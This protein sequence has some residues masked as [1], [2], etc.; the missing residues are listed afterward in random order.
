MKLKKIV[1][2]VISTLVMELVMASHPMILLWYLPLLKSTALTSRREPL[3][4]IP[5]TRRLWDGLL[6]GE[7]L[8]VSE[9]HSIIGFWILSTVSNTKYVSI[10]QYIFVVKH[11]VF[12][13]IGIGVLSYITIMITISL[14][15]I[16]QLSLKRTSYTAKHMQQLKLKD[17]SG[18]MCSSLQEHVLYRII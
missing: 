5:I 16:C 8:V 11:C 1:I 14:I 12:Y 6:A 10:I 18:Y 15:S 4:R 17:H 2:V 7:E 13:V 3:R 9:W